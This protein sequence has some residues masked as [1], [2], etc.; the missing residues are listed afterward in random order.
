MITL[1]AL[2]KVIFAIL[3]FIPILIKAQVEKPEKTSKPYRI[4][5]SG[6]Q[7]TIKSIKDMK[8]LMVWTASGHRILEQK[9]MNVQSYDF[10]ID[11]KEKYFF[12]MIQLSD[13]KVFTEKIGIP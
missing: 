5:T 7:V 3:V 13:G 6:K 11:V 4:L 9:E 12:M 10:R 8:S 1:T 2:R